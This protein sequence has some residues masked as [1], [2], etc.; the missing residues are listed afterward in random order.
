ME[1]GW[2]EKRRS[3]EANYYLKGGK[4]NAGYEMQATAS[5]RSPMRD[6]NAVHSGES[7]IP[8]WLYYNKPYIL[9]V[10]SAEIIYLFT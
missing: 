9:L 4:L 7:S 10:N 3:R 1:I 2:G 8:L 5:S 6:R